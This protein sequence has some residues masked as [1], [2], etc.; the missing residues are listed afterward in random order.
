MTL[1]EN[2]SDHDSTPKKT[3]ETPT[4]QVLMLQVSLRRTGEH[5][6]AQKCL[7]CSYLPQAYCIKTL[8]WLTLAIAICEVL[9]IPVQNL[10]VLNSGFNSQSLCS[11]SPGTHDIGNNSAGHR[12]PV[13]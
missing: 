7:C 11:V 10:H 8:E 9:V 13:A 2:N 5:R 4:P 1:S 12:Q 3:I 6:K